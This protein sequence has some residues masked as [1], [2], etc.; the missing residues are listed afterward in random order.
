MVSRMGTSSFSVQRFK[1]ISSTNDWLLS[2]ARG[3]AA[4][5]TVVVADFQH[6]GRGR[7]DRRWE[8]PPGTSLLASVLL[9][10]PLAPSERHLATVAVGLSALEAC[11]AVA[12]LRA[13]LKW[14]NDIVVS[15][16]KLG[17][18]LAESD[19]AAGSPAIVVGIGLN[20]TWPGPP[21]ADGTSVLEE[22]GSSVERDVLLD[23]LLFGLG[24]HADELS[25]PAGR[26][27]LLE[28]YRLRLAT[29]GR[30]VRVTLADGGFVGTAVGV[31]D[32][33]HLLVDTPSGVHEVA[34]G[35]VVHVRPD[36]PGATERRE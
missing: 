6:R 33:G 29:L 8:A 24:S 27:S 1:E 11:Q 2:A 3:G 34:A 23:A 28:A 7:L 26:S 30:T 35:D 5:R 13:G 12:A 32:L 20:L 14:P 18:L 4:D 21:D 9:R 25:S 31:N 15:D 17:G 19:A 22:T 16:R 36:R 10:V